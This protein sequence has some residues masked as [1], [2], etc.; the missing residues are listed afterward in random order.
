LEQHN[1]KNEADQESI[2]LEL[3]NAR[4]A[5]V[6]STYEAD[7]A[8]KSMVEERLHLHTKMLTYWH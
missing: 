4:S 1:A 7:V 2:Y 6:K 5:M 8:L 3:E